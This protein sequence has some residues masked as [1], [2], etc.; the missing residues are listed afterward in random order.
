MALPTEAHH[1]NNINRLARCLGKSPPIDLQGL[2]GAAPKQDP[3]ERERPAALA[4][5]NGA[6]KNGSYEKATTTEYRTTDP[7]AASRVRVENKPALV[8]PR[9][10]A[11]HWGL[12]AE[13]G[14]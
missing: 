11:E 3:P 4:G 1:P 6:K 9:I 7:D 14:P 5:A 8:A 13:G 2:S 10:I 12:D